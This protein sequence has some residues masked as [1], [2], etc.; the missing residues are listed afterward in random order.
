MRRP[1][2]EREQNTNKQRS[3][4]KLPQLT[5]QTNKQKRTKR[6][7]N[8][9]AHE[10]QIDSHSTACVLRWLIGAGESAAPVFPWES[11]TLLFTKCCSLI[12]S[13]SAIHLTWTLPSGCE[14]GEAAPFF[15]FLQVVCTTIMWVNIGTQFSPWSVF[16]VFVCFIW[17]S[18]WELDTW[19]FLYMSMSHWLQLSCSDRLLTNTE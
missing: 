16:F 6:N 13:A 10:K 19:Q 15:F 18:S 9:V 12:I 11:L 5:K 14:A 7:Q 2:V 17:K 3:K 8:K 1:K 4:C